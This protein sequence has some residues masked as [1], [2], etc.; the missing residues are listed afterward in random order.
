M[1]RLVIL[2]LGYQGGSIVYQDTLCIKTATDENSIF[3]LVRGLGTVCLQLG[4]LAHWMLRRRR[5]QVPGLDQ[6]LRLDG[7]RELLD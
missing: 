6:V 5:D 7:P 3:T 2:S 4:Q 1:S